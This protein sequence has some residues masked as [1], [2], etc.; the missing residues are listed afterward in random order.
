MNV[1]YSQE[2]DLDADEAVAVYVASGLGSR[3]P[4]DDAPRMRRMLKEANLVVTGRF[5]GQLI[6]VARSLTDW[7]YVTY[8]SDLAVVEEWQRRGVGRALIEA[9]RREAP[10]TKLVLLSAPAAS[11]YYPALGFS[12][13]ESAW[14]LPA[15]NDER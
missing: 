15:M 2:S 4:V 6:G 13:H 7:S 5:Q 8:L 9:T 3:R 14:W 11:S 12:R 10:S 1:T